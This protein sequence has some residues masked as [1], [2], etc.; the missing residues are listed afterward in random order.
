MTE[1][2]IFLIGAGPIGLELAVALQ[3]AQID[4]VHTDAQQVGQTIARFPRFVKFF[5]STERISICGVPLMTPDQ[6]KATREQYLAYLFGIVQQFDLKISGYEPV[7]RIEP[8]VTPDERFTIVTEG[9]NGKRVYRAAKVIAAIGG[10]HR[11]RQLKHATQ[12]ACSGADLP[13]VSH[14]FVEPHPYVG[15]RLLIVGGKNSAI[16]AAIQCQRAGA[17][18]TLSYR[19]K[20][21]P[22]DVKYWLKPEIQSLIEAGKVIYHPNTLPTHISPAQVTLSPTV[23]GRLANVAPKYDIK[24]D[25][26]FVLLLIGYEM[27]TTLLEMAGVE[28]T[29]PCQ[30]PRHDPETMQTNV[31]GLYMAGTAAGGTQDQFNLFIE[32]CHSHVVRI[33]RAL[34]GR[35]PPHVNR[36]A[37]HHLHESVALLES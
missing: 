12:S 25:A 15:Q 19:N 28:L 32:N 18:V 35:E 14:Y 26:D 33:I 3:D 6:N 13:H 7:T 9:R 1:T 11:P 37:Y 10:L 17:Q 2:E 4:Y 5:S 30:T 21:L 29:G 22:N 8:P 34:A 16:E 31:P 36:L 27:D 20:N 24:I 23:G